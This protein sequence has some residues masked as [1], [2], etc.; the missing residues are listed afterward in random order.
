[1]PPFWVSRKE[2]SVD[3]QS[4]GRGLYSTCDKLQL[5]STVESASCL[6]SLLKSWAELDWILL[7]SLRHAPSDQSD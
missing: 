4:D 6:Y 1:M 3:G 5:S 2:E 7:C